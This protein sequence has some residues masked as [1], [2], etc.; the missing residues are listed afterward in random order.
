MSHHRIILLLYVIC[1]CI[2]WQARQGLQLLADTLTAYSTA[3]GPRAL[4]SFAVIRQRSSLHSSL[5]A[6]AFSDV[7]GRP[8]LSPRLLPFASVT[9]VP[10]YTDH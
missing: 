9:L 1:L 7:S 4:A 10:N 6:E 2:V 5:A 8:H 3:V